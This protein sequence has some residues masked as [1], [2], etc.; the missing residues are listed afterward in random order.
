[1]LRHVWQVDAIMSS[2]QRD[3]PLVRGE[4]IDQRW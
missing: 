4:A 2:I 1:L 3:G